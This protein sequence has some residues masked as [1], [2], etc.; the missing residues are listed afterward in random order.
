KWSNQYQQKVSERTKCSI[1][2]GV[3]HAN[4][5]YVQWTT[6]HSVELEARH[7]NDDVVHYAESVTFFLPYSLFRERHG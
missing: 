7:F 3:G 4:S 2:S 5:V 1:S 6:V